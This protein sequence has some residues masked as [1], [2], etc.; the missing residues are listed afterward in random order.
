MAPHMTSL[1]AVLL[2]FCRDR[3][4]ATLH[5]VTT[6]AASRVIYYLFCEEL[7]QLSSTFRYCR[8]FV[9]NVPQCAFRA[10]CCVLLYHIVFRYVSHRFPF[11]K[12]KKSGKRSN[13]DRINDDAW[14]RLHECLNVLMLECVNAWVADAVKLLKQSS[15]QTI[16]QSASAPQWRRDRLPRPRFIKW[17]LCM[18]P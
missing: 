9:P 3:M 18:K 4:E 15:N 12:R 1:C 16:K 2:F 6:L 11:V 17:Q 8:I 7:R 10:R 14:E 5:K 13:N